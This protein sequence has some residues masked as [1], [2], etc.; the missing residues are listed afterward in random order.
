MAE[1]VLRV[2]RRREYAAAVLLGVAVVAA[3]DEI[4]FHQILRWHHFYD[5][6]TPAFGLVSD[7]LL[8]AGQ[9]F[10]AAAGF[11]L[12]LDARRRGGFRHDAAWAGFLVGTGAFQLWDGTVNHKLLR[13]HQIR[14]DVEIL[15]YDV[16]WL[17]VAVALLAVGIA[18]T[19]AC[20]RRPSAIAAS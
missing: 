16:A 10:C 17:V 13:L 4:V 5:L 1:R 3:L 8:H 11:F 6:S 9:L 20:S 14:Y 15:P 12:M 18:L 19:V 2:V 7:G